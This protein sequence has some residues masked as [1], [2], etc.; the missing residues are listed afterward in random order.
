MAGLEQ[1]LQH[2]EARL[3]WRRN[4]TRHRTQREQ[5]CC[6]RGC[7][8]PCSC[9]IIFNTIQSTWTIIFIIFLFYFYF[10]FSFYFYFFKQQSDVRDAIRWHFP[11]AQAS[12]LLTLQANIWTWFMMEWLARTPRNKS[13][14]MHQLMRV[15]FIS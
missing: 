11:I 14:R 10:I 9:N 5:W 12:A 3:S 8:P 6:R 15:I 7:C 2:R 4:N 1:I 13:E